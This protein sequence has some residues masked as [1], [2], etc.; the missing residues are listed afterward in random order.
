LSSVVD[1]SL[2]DRLVTDLPNANFRRAALELLTIWKQEA[3]YLSLNMEMGLLVH[4]QDLAVQ[5]DAH[6]NALIHQKVLELA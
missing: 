5:I 4:S 6:I 3:P 1:A 2:K